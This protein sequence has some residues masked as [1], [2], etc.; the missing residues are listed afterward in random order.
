MTQE[1]TAVCLTFD[2]D[3]LS[4]WLASERFTSPAKLSRGEYGARVAVHPGDASAL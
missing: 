2:F 3:A 4:V 1:S